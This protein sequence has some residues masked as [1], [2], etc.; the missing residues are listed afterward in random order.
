MHCRG[1]NI[2]IHQLHINICSGRKCSSRCLASDPHAKKS[3]LWNPQDQLLIAELRICEHEKK[4][5][6][7][8]CKPCQLHFDI[9]EAWGS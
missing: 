5:R 2:N 8:V 6:D 9:M 3:L 4:H 1:L 7:N